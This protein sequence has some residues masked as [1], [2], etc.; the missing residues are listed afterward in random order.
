MTIGASWRSSISRK[1]RRFSLSR[2]FAISTGA[3]TST[4]PVLSFIACSSA[5][6]RIDSDSDSTLRMRP[7]P[8]QRGQTIWLD[9]PKL[10]AGA[11]ATSRAG[12]SG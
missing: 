11:G 10:G 8:S 12:R 4:W 2:K 5:R 9:S 1:A 6:R 3:C 7:W